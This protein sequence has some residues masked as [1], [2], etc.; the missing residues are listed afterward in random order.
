MKWKNQI[1]Q[2]I[3]I[4][5]IFLWAYAAFSKLLDYEKFT[6]QLRKSPILT[7]FAIF[8]ALAVPVIEIV[9]VILLIFDRTRMTGLFASFS[10]MV[11]FSAYIFAVTR[12]TSDVPCSCGGILEKMDWNTHLLFNIFFVLLALVGILINRQISKPPP[13]SATHSYKSLLQ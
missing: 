2:I 7:K 5:F 13:E 1:V 9:I 4:L 12:F 6:V 10:L 11:A 8:L 3:S